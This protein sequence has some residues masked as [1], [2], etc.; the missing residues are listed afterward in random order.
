MITGK[1]YIISAPSGAGK[2]SLV[3]RLRQDMDKLV[4]SVSHTTRGMRSGESHGGD[5][6]FVSTAEFQSMI[7]RRDFLEH[8]QVFDNFYGTAQ[9]T[10]EDNLAQGLD[11]ILEIDWQG[12]QQVRKMLPDSIS[13]FILP[14][15]IE[16]LKQRLQNRGQDNEETIARRMGDAVTEMSHYPEFD[17]LIV[18]DDFD[19]ALS[20]LKSVVTANRLLQTTQQQM[21]APLLQ[22]L[23]N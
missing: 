8:A 5:Y 13:I 9:K 16:V 18:N 17:Y 6:F 19:L 2:T 14:P 1:L 11:V 7:E 22:N 23:L 21:L 3:K 20:Q 4:V 10:V 15:S 12:A